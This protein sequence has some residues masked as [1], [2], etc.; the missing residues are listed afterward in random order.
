MQ[1]TFT[2]TIARVHEKQFSGQASSVTVP[3]KDG[4]MTILAHHTPIIATLSK[5]MLRVVSDAEI[6]EI[7]IDR[8]MLE[9]SDNTVTILIS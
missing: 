9:V 6:T 1:S 7:A 8:G 4:E 5:G 3:A 2:L